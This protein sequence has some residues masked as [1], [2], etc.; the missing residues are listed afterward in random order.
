[1]QRQELYRQLAERL[2]TREDVDWGP[3]ALPRAEKRE[4]RFDDIVVPAP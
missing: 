4:V 1:V 3:L 2:H